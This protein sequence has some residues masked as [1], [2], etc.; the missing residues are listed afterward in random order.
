MI[1]G[2]VGMTSIA[3]AAVVGPANSGP[4]DQAVLAMVSSAVKVLS[5]W[6]GLTADSIGCSIPVQ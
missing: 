1:G 6:R 3:A 2:R 4:G 5:L